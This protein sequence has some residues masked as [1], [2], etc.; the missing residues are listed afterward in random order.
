MT[1]VE[2]VLVRN[3]E[4]G[5]V[6]EDMP[7]RS[8]VRSSSLPL[9]QEL[10]RGITIYKVEK[11][12]S[13]GMNK[14]PSTMHGVPTQNYSSGVDDDASDQEEAY[15][16]QTQ[17][18]VHRT[19]PEDSRIHYLLV[20]GKESSGAKRLLSFV[21]FSREVFRELVLC[22]KVWPISSG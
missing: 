10:G 22:W 6:T 11:R 16:L 21:T 15:I 14:S 12:D 17:P 3:Q 8:L 7:A 19:R 13:T 5:S 18:V 9:T 20:N 4:F 2:T 1:K